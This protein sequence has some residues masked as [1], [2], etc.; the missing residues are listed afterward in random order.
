MAKRERVKVELILAEL[1]LN[2][3]CLCSIVVVRT[4]NLI[5]RSQL[6]SLIP[7]DSAILGSKDL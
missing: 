4:Q 2:L 3:N 1:K 7:V 6:A 5:H